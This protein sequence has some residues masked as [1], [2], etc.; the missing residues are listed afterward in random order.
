[1]PPAASIQTFLRAESRRISNPDI[2][3]RHGRH[4][5]RLTKSR[6]MLLV[7]PLHGP[8]FFAGLQTIR[9]L[10]LKPGTVWGPC[11]GALYYLTRILIAPKVTVR[12]EAPLTGLS[13]ALPDPLARVI[14]SSVS[15]PMPEVL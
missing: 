12:C 4:D 15:A 7:S 2:I 10:P 5:L 6:V 14:D 9:Q 11:D 1:M 13:L 3:S 8:P